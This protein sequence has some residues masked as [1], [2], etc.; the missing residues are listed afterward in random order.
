MFLGCLDC[1]D[2]NCVA[3]IRKQTRTNVK[4]VKNP[5]RQVTQCGFAAVRTDRVGQ[6]GNLRRIGNPPRIGS[7]IF[8]GRLPIGRRLPTCPTKLVRL[9][10]ECESNQHI[11][12]RNGNQLLPPA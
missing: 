3:K 6:V 8:T 9:L 7:G 5:H 11:S 12:N 2:N 1:C 10:F 4:G